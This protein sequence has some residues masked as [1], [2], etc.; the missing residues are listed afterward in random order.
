MFPCILYAGHG[1]PTIIN[2]EQVLISGTSASTP[3]ITAF[4]ALINNER[5]AR[6]MPPMGF[7]NP[8]IYGVSRMS[9][10]LLMSFTD[11]TTGNNACTSRDCCLYGFN[12]AP[13]W[14]PVTGLGSPIFDALLSH[15]LAI[16]KPSCMHDR[17]MQTHHNHNEHHSRLR[18]DAK[19]VDH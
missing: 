12:A 7:V 14:D 18:G 11:I 1:Y 3:V 2:G 16:P 19:V 4:F 8:F 5:L 17:W 15:A 10:G 9:S 6:G 13:G